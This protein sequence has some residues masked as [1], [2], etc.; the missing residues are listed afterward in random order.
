QHAPEV[1][2]RTAVYTLQIAE[3]DKFPQTE[4]FKAEC[5]ENCTADTWHATAIAAG[6]RA[7]TS[8][9]AV[10]GSSCLHRTNVQVRHEIVGSPMPSP[11]PPLAPSA[12]ERLIVSAVASALGGVQKRDPSEIGRALDRDLAD[13]LVKT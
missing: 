7:S 5:S 9:I 12:L 1:P 3:A 10:V 13:R 11:F 2:K 6:D 8:A 4:A